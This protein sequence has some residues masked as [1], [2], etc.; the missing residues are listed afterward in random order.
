MNTIV[1]VA[2]W[3]AIIF[4]IAN[5]VLGPGL[6][7]KERSPLTAGGYVASFV[8]VVL[9]VILAGRGLGWW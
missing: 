2:S 3:L 6:I 4:S 1:I 7:G 9:F 8:G 5:I